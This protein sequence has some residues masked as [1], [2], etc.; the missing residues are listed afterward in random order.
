MKIKNNIL[1]WTMLFLSN[2]VLAQR[3]VLSIPVNRPLD[4]IYL[5]IYRLDN[6]DPKEDRYGIEYT[7]TFG[8]LQ[9]SKKFD[10]DSFYQWT[11]QFCIEKVGKKFFYKNFKL[12][13]YSFKDEDKTEIYTITYLIEPFK[14]SLLQDYG[15]NFI[16]FTFKNYNF[17]GK[18]MVET[19]DN[20]P[21]CVKHPELCRFK[22]DRKRVVKLTNKKI[23]KGAKTYLNRGPYMTLNK[24]FQW[25]V[26][27][28]I[29]GI[30]S[31]TVDSRTGKMSE[32]KTGF[33]CGLGR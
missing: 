24:D 18:S 26:R 29:E 22:Y 4:S 33:R 14:D 21:D 12:D 27:V 23:V 5:D 9:N 30:K 13:M 11:Q 10:T 20:I 1:I 32:I 17:S 28:E 25:E 8:L 3:Q 7:R 31:F 16:K 6:P 15:D 2:G 19:P